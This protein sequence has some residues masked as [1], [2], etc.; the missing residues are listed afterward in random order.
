MKK[1]IIALVLSLLIILPVLGIALNAN[2]QPVIWSDNSA[3]AMAGTG[4][5][6]NANPQQTIANIIK[7]L[8]GFLGMIAVVIIL[9]GGFKWMTAAGN[10]D[11]IG[12]AKKIMTAG[13]IGLV[14]VL[15]SFGLATYITTTLVTSI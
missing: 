14:I 4:L 10:E 7:I 11:K 12:E 8:L 15:A 5:N 9:I 2:A 3:N 6:G 13:L 1:N